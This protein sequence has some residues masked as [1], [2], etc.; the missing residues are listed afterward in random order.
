[1]GIQGFVVLA[2]DK[3][4]VAGSV[5]LAGQNRPQ[6]PSLVIGRHIDA[7][8]LKQRGGHIEQFNQRITLLP[9]LHARP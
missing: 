2:A 7:R 3:I 1:M 5:G 4:A 8:Q 6:R 9:L